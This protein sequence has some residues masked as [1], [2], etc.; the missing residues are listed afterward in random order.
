MSSEVDETLILEDVEEDDAIDVDEDFEP[1]QRRRSTMTS[2]SGVLTPESR[3]KAREALDDS[4]AGVGPSV[5]L[6]IPVNF[7]GSCIYF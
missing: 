7:R 5:S 6:L 2:D 4:L 1:T 3:R